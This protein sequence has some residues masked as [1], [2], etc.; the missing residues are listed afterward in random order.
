VVGQLSLL[1]LLAILAVFHRE[2]DHT[3]T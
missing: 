1:R 3:V 2:P